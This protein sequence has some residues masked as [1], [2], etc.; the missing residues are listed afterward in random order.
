M[1]EWLWSQKSRAC[2]ILRFS[3]DLPIEYLSPI[4]KSCRSN[5]PI[6]E[7]DGE[8]RSHLSTNCKRK[9]W[10]PLIR[11][12]S[13]GA[14]SFPPS[15]SRLGK[16]GYAAIDRHRAS[17]ADEEYS[18]KT[19][20]RCGIRYWT[21]ITTFALANEVQKDHLCRGKKRVNERR[22]LHRWGI[23]TSCELLDVSEM[24]LG[25]SSGRY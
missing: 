24:R 16:F 22:C 9:R 18:K 21:S 6:E 11:L 15:A 25:N 10:R 12:R 5:N 1:Q 14:S 4:K 20:R 13:G 3:F 17:S 8:G 19:R 7:E 23:D 2:N